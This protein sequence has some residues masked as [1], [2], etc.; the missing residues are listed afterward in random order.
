MQNVHFCLEFAYFAEIKNFL[1][2][3]IWVI[4][5]HDIK[6]ISFEGKSPPQ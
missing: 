4:G 2:S 1:L 5:P 3:H 6:Y